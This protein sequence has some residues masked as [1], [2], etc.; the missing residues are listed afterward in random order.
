MSVEINNIIIT[1]VIK[2]RL[3]WQV[4]PKPGR[5]RTW[6]GSSL[7]KNRENIDLTWLSQ[8]LKSTWDKTQV[9]NTLTFLDKV[10][11]PRF[12][13]YF[14]TKSW[15]NLVDCP[16]LWP[17][18]DLGSALESGFKTMIKITFINTPTRINPR[19]P[20]RPVIWPLPRSTLELGF[21]ITII[22]TLSLH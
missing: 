14:L 12:F 6:N 3:T 10:K 21:K 2:P 16:G 22:T 19:W 20:F 18:H 8:K 17:E 15:V 4:N 1:L 9:K 11:N 7:R 5:L 13:D